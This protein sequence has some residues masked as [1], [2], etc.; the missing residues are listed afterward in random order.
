[1]PSAGILTLVI[2][3]SRG[4]LTV[5]SSVQPRIDHIEANIAKVKVGIG[6]V[7]T[8]GKCLLLIINSSI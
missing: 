6:C 3:A 1:V 7:S 8:C 4:G 2:I 5:G